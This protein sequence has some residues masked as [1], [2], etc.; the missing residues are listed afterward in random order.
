MYILDY[1]MILEGKSM[2]QLYEA[3]SEI[4]KNIQ[5]NVKS[6]N[7]SLSYWELEAL[8]KIGSALR[9]PLHVDS[10]VGHILPVLNFQN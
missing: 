1:Y 8:S 9:K 10:N 3:H 2:V 4:G 6:P 5:K 7:L